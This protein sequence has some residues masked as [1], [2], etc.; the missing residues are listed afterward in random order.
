M[1]RN[2]CANLRRYEYQI[3]GLKDYMAD[4]AMTYF[5][6]PSYFGGTSPPPTGVFDT[7]AQ[8]FPFP[9]STGGTAATF[10]YTPVG[11]QATFPVVSNA[12]TYPGV[13]NGS[14]FTFF[15]Q[16]GGTGSGAFGYFTITGGVASAPNIYSWA[17]GSGYTGGLL[18]AP[19]SN[20]PYGLPNYQTPSSYWANFM[21]C[22]INY[23][24]SG[25]MK[26]IPQGSFSSPVPTFPSGLAPALQNVAGIGLQQCTRSLFQRVG[27]RQTGQIR[28]TR[29]ARVKRGI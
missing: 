20:D 19:L 5:A 9:N 13:A 23:T 8:G 24:G 11:G 10:T 6:A 29:K 16:P 15:T 7:A 14:Y 25:I 22:L 1:I 21:S 26:R 3:R 18:T 4:D 27:N 28:T 17:Q 12:G 2:E